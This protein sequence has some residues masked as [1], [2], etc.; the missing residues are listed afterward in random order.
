LLFPQR[1]PLPQLP[2]HARYVNHQN[3]CYDWGTYGWL[4]LRSG[5]VNIKQYRYYFFINSSVRGP[6]LP[7]YAKVT[8]AE[9]L[10]LLNA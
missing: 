10:L 2:Q 8:A 7:A 6:Y 3:E 1:V 4:L 5:L 9:I